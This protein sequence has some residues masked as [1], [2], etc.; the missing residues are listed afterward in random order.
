MDAGRTDADGAA[1]YGV[2]S[3][4]IERRTEPYDP[5]WYQ[6]GA[7]AADPARSAAK[8]KGLKPNE[9]ALRPT[10]R[11]PKMNVDWGSAVFAPDADAVVR[12]SGGHCA[13]SG[14]APQVYDVKT[15]RWSIPF[16]PELP[17]EFVYSNDQV[18]GEWS[19]QGN[20]WMACHTYKTTGYDPNL[21]CLVYAAHDYTYFFDPTTGKW[22]RNGEQ[23]PFRRNCFVVTLCTTPKGAVVWADKRDHDAAGLWRLDADK[24][25]WQPLPLTGDLP[26]KSP[27]Q[28]GMAYDSKRDR[29]LFFSNADKNK[30]DVTAYDLK[31]GEAKSLNATGMDKA[32]APSRETVY[33]P[34]ADAVL[35]GRAST[36]TTSSA[37]CCTTAART[38]GSAWNCLAPTRSARVREAIRSTTRWA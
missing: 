37:G 27:D 10:P 25:T 7:P 36:P 20:P 8:L 29:L 18:G 15:E 16:A 28:H 3:G 21:K 5:A 34:D 26:A 11:S 30:G 4:A 33:I 9:W 19:F 38:P 32:A 24:R 31:T 35:V 23:N 1:Q 22:S 2:K 13:Y 6:E 17:L 14:T 12:F